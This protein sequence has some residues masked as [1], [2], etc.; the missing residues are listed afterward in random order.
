[1]SQETVLES[2]K[3][4][5]KRTFS[6]SVERV[7]KAWTDPAQMARWYAPNERWRFCDVTVDPTPGGRYDVK[8]RHQDGDEFHV[9]G[10]YL[11]MVPHTHLSFTWSV[12]GTEMG[13]ENT[14]VTIDLRPVSGGTELTLTHDRQPSLQTVEG[15]SVGWTGC[16]DLL[17]SY[18]AGKPLIGG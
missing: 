5:I 7:Y 14:L 1:M 2:Q 18:L 8:M 9:A 13:L 3:L 11:E 6:A 4:V 17:E 15:T 10:E 12:V 16:L